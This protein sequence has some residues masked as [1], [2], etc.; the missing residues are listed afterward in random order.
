MLTVALISLVMAERCNQSHH[1]HQHIGLVI[2]HSSPRRSECLPRQNLET[3][4]EFE[5][6][7]F[8]AAYFWRQPP[9]AIT[10]L[11]HLPPSAYHPGTKATKASIAAHPILLDWSN[12]VGLN[13]SCSFVTSDYWQPNLVDYVNPHLLQAK[14]SKYDADNP[15][16][17]HAMYGSFGDNFWKACETKFYSL[18]N[19]LNTWDLVKRTPD[20]HVQPSAWAF[21]IKR[22]L[23]DLIKIQSALV[24][25]SRPTTS[26]HQLLGDMVASYILVYHSYDYDLSSDGK[27]SIGTV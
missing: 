23:D 14:A 27:F 7:S 15:D 18:V 25:S 13:D 17:K 21:K 26:W 9:A 2:Y 20:K 5:P 10:N 19:D 24:R 11:G 12:D 1:K 3:V 6:S 8:S 4:E 16:W 22:F